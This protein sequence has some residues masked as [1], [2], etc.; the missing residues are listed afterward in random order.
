MANIL[1]TIFE[2]AAPQS[3]H[4][5]SQDRTLKEFILAHS[6]MP[7]VLVTL[8]SQTD[9]YLEWAQSAQI[10]TLTKQD[11]LRDVDNQLTQ[12]AKF[13]TNN[14]NARSNTSSSFQNASLDVVF[15]LTSI[16]VSHLFFW[17]TPLKFLRN[18]DSHLGQALRSLLDAL[19]KTWTSGQKNNLLEKRLQG[20]QWGVKRFSNE[21]WNRI[22]KH[23]TDHHIIPP[24]GAIISFHFT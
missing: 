2:V 20:Q 21:W 16:F 4:H 18:Q 19:H 3:S 6:A 1:T 9:D 10:D 13:I 23:L 14:L 8:A 24:Q 5:G 22:F 11:V 17:S 15:Y 12:L 7:Q